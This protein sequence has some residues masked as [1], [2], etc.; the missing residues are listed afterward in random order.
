MCQFTQELWRPAVWNGSLV[1]FIGHTM[2]SKKLKVKSKS[3][4]WNKSKRE[5]WKFGTIHWAVGSLTAKR[6][7]DHRQVSRVP[8]DK[9]ARLAISWYL[10]LVFIVFVKFNQNDYKHRDGNVPCSVIREQWTCWNFQWKSY[11]EKKQGPQSGRYN[12]RL[13]YLQERQEKNLQICSS[14][15]SSF[16]PLGVQ[17]YPTWD[18]LAI[19]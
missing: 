17:N 18:V 2:K 9:L 10:D 6:S 14:Y 15:S 1:Q 13:P 5:K 7:G 3:K 19:W 12:T 4:I 16:Q 8:S 11:K